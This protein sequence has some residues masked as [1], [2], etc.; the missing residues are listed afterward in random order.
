MSKK[1][2]AAVPIYILSICNEW[3]ERS[4]MK[5]IMVTT[6]PDKVRKAVSRLIKRREVEYGGRLEEVDNMELLEL[7]HCLNY[8]Y[9]SSHEDGELEV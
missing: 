8:A 4:S 5:I 2:S 6:N 1:A 7:N 9:I 3:K